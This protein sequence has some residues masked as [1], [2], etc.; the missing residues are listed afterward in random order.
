MKAMHG[1]E[2]WKRKCI[3]TLTLQTH[4][5]GA[6]YENCTTSHDNCVEFCAAHKR[7]KPQPMYLREKRAA[8]DVASV[9]YALL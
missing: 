1:V 9:A 7:L 4:S 6:T 5:N 3:F 8:M 2:Y